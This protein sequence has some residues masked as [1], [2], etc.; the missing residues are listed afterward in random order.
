MD[1]PIGIILTGGQSTRMGH[2]DKAFIM[3]QDKPLIMQTIARLSPQ[4]SQ[5]LINANRNIENYRQLGYPVIKDTMGGYLGPL[6]G[7]LAALTYLQQQSPPLSAHITDVL[8]SPVDVPLLPLDYYARMRVAK[9]KTPHPDQHVYVAHD[10]TRQQSL[11][12]ML[13]LVGKNSIENYCQDLQQTLSKRQHKVQ[14][15]LEG[16]RAIEVDFSDEA[17]C[18][19]NINTPNDL[20]AVM[21]SNDS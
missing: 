17:S 8:V 9:S 10:G 16:Q 3:L 18:F 21:D 14:Q 1:K 5:L 19:C 20:N 13:P 7:I 4:V 15:W 11:C 6:A 2:S 12:M